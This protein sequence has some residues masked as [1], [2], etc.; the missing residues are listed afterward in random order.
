M[1]GKQGWFSLSLSFLAGPFVLG[2]VPG[3]DG[4]WSLPFNAPMLLPGLD[5]QTFLLQ[6]IFQTT[7]GLR[8]GSPTSFTLLEASL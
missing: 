2:V 1:P 5:A 6:P 4:V 3:P 7:G 8:L